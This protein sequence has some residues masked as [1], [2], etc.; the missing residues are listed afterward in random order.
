MVAKDVHIYLEDVAGHITAM[1][2]VANGF[3]DVLNRAHSNYLAQISIELTEAS[4]SMGM[5][6]KKVHF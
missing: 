1:D 6:M 4:N 5:T 3:H 2:Q